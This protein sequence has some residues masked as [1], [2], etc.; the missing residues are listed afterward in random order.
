MPIGAHIAFVSCNETHWGGSEELW[1]AAAAELARRG[2][3]VSVAKPN[4]PKGEPAIRR[5]HE[6][7][8]TLH[9]LAKFPLLPKAFYGIF[10]LISRAAGLSWQ[11][12][13][14]RHRAALLPA[15]PGDPVAGRQLGMGSSMPACCGGWASPMR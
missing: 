9:D 2:H 4:L 7:K 13:A 6:A 14:P 1:G 10:S 11:T 5:L 8:C 3:R 15:R 12:A